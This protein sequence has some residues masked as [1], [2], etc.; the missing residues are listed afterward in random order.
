MLNNRKINELL[1]LLVPITLVLN[2]RLNGLII[3]LLSVY[4][5]YYLL[6]GK[7]KLNFLF[8][9]SI[10]YFIIIVYSSFIDYFS[11]TYASKYIE[12]SLG[13]LFLPLS[14]LALR[15][16][17]SIKNVLKNIVTYVTAINVLLLVFGLYR[18][19]T[20]H[21]IVYG[22]WSKSVT[23]EF[24]KNTNTDIINWGML[25]YTKL[26]EY[27]D[28]HPAYYGLII[29]I[30]IVILISLFNNNIITKKRFYTFLPINIFFLI[31]LSSK[32]NLLAI[33][34][35]GLIMLIQYFKYFSLEQKIIITI[36]TIFILFLFLIIPPTRMRIERSIETLANKTKNLSIDIS[37]NERLILWNAAIESYKTNP[38]FGIGNNEGYESIMKLSGIDKNTHNQYLQILVNTGLF[39]LILF[40]FYL[41]APLYFSRFN[42][43]IVFGIIFF[44]AFNLFTENALDRQW[45]IVIVSFFYSAIIFNDK[46]ESEVKLK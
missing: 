25:T 5:I 30:V 17:Y 12:T 24:Y 2:M 4:S 7:I 29:N 21:E 1:L 38:I 19:L 11:G 42:K 45:G 41:F 31:L 40:L 37:T 27:L 16:K 6:R 13:A 35:Y 28:T 20:N 15:S 22:M 33:I 46:Y 10:I 43:D 23:E 26:I 44:V 18:A 8:L 36:T 34:I 39:G 32:A 14:F 3:I 9:I